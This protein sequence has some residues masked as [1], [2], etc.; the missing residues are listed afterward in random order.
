[1]LLAAD[2]ANATPVEGTNL[3]V[4]IVSGS[5]SGGLSIAHGDSP[6]ERIEFRSCET[7]LS[8]N[9]DLGLFQVELGDADSELACRWRKSGNGYRYDWCFDPGVIVSFAAEPRNDC[10]QLCYGIKNCTS[11][12]LTQVSLH[13]C[14]VT[15]AAP[16]FAGETTAAT[17][18][19]KTPIHAEMYQRLWLWS[20]GRSFSF[21]SLPGSDREPHLAV[22]RAGQPR[23]EWAWWTNADATFDAPLIALANRAR[24]MTV[25]LWFERAIWASANVGDARSCFHLFPFFGSLKSGE[26]AE[27]RGTLVWSTASIDEL[28]QRLMRHD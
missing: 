14:V 26:R 2:V 13:P 10:L 18:L 4:S 17:R 5:R 8:G 23:I 27:V 25:G 28:H 1:M 22:M 7:I 24:S 12:P 9:R 20:R 21:G 3:V 15:T 6:D 16:S 11:R 19:R